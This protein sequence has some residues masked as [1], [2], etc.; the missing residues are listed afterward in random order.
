MPVPPATIS[1]AGSSSTGGSEK[2]PN[3]PSTSSRV[4]GAAR[5]RCGSGP[6]LSSTCTSSSMFPVRAVSEGAEAME[7]GLR[8]GEPWSPTITA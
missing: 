2:L 5:S 7:Y 4:P 1:R 3:G 6:P 8:K